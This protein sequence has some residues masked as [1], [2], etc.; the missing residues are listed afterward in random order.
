MSAVGLYQKVQH[1]GNVVPRLYLLCT[2]GSCA[3]R[4]GSPETKILLKD[5]EDMCKGVQHPI[6]GL[7]LRAYLVQVCRGLLPDTRKG[8]STSETS[9][10]DSIRFLLENF[11]EMNKLWVRM[12]RQGGMDEATRKNREKERSQLADLVG[13]NLTQLSQLENLQFVDY[14]EEVLPKILEQV[15]ACKDELAQQY[16]MECITAAFPDEFQVG[17]MGQLLDTL[18]K[19]E[20]NV[21]LAAVMGSLLDRLSNY[22]RGNENVTHQLDEAGALGKMS[23][24]VEASI[25]AHSDITGADIASMYAGLLSFAQAV[26]PDR[27][28]YIDN[29]LGRA[30]K[31]LETK[32]PFGDPKSERRI[33]DFLCI[34]LEHNDLKIVLQLDNFSGLLH[35]LSV[36]KQKDVAY[37][38]AKEIIAK[39]DIITSKTH[40]E[41]LLNILAPLLEDLDGKCDDEVCTVF[42]HMSVLCLCPVEWLCLHSIFRYRWIDCA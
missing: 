7:F 14:K 5:M 12:K 31:I 29:I 6:R 41:S 28:E 16:L 25:Q 4:G 26:Y 32:K 9:V 13:K 24:A 37:K 33:V 40:A 15:V 30:T 21:H 8:D 36:A 20:S 17:T 18:P 23:E 34:P 22:S 42:G 10:K 19:L 11:I 39:Q 3:I 2:A 35:V 38:V 1:A 27:I